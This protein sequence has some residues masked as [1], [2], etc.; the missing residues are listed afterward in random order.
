MLNISP[1]SVHG[2]INQEEYGAFSPDKLPRTNRYF[3]N[4]LLGLIVCFLIVL[5]LPWTQNIQSKGNLTTLQPEDRP[6]T[7]HSTI[8]GRIEKWFVQEGQLVKA[9]DTIVYL[10]EIKDAYFDPQLVSRTSNQLASKTGSIQAYRNKMQALERQIDAL[11]KGFIQKQAQLRQKLNQARLKKNSAEADLEQ[12]KLDKQIAE[13]Q[14]YRTDS[15]FK[16]GVK[17]RT[18]LEMKQLKVQETQAKLVAS[19]N[20]LQEAVNEIDITQLELD[21]LDNEFQEK[22]SKAESDYFQT[23]S[24]AFEGELERTKLEIALANYTIRNQFYYILAPQDC[25]ITQAITPGIGETIKEGDPIVT[26]MP[27]NFEL[28]VEM[29]VNPLDLPLVAKEQEVR[30]IFDGWPAFVFAGWPNLSTGIFSG[31]IVAIDNTISSN[32]KYRVLVA[33]KPDAPWPDALRPGTGAEGIAL[34]STVPVWYELWR[35]LNGFPPDFYE[36]TGEK[37]PK[38]KIPLKTVAK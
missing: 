15:L 31:E 19:D 33:P 16:I 12:A 26:I 36:D 38:L 35:Q 8:P 9:G 13:V 27:A 29:Y 32:G 20:K 5:F 6:Q 4:W 2:Q 37:L 10:S 23:A 3:A 25:Y 1:N 21:N 11:Q 7:I 24:S 17:S 34:L 30:F 14:F 18:E 28:A 22:I